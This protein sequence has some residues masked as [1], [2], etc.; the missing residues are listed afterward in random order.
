MCGVAGLW[1][2]A[3]AQPVTTVSRMLGTIRHRG[4]DSE[5]L[6]VSEDRRLALGHRRLAIV[7]LTA[8][9]AQPMTSRSGR[10]TLVFNGEIYN[11]LELRLCLKGPWRGHSDTETLLAAIERMGLEHALQ[12]CVGM[13][14]IALWDAHEHTLS[15]A[16]DRLG[17]KPLY[18][19]HAPGVTAFSSELKALA[20]V[21][22]I[23]RT[24][25]PESLRHYVRLGYIPAPR[26][27]WKGVSKLMPG[28]LLVLSAPGEGGQVRTYWQ[29][30]TPTGQ[31]SGSSGS[32]ART[33]AQWLDELESMLDTAVSGQMLSDVPLGAFLS[34]GIDSSLI[35]A[36]M[37]RASARPVRT[38][39]MGV[40]DWK[41]D[42]SVHAARVA[43]HLGTDHTTLM[44][45]PTDVLAVVPDLV[46]IYDEPFA[47]SSQ[48]PTVL[49]SRL[50]RSHV[51][52]ALSGDAGDELFGGYNRHVTADRLEHALN[53][54][55]VALRRAAGTALAAVPARLWDALASSTSLR[56]AIRL[57]PDMSEKMGRLARFLSATSSQQAYQGTVSQWLDDARMPV[58]GTLPALALPTCDSVPLA[59][60]MMW[61]DMQSYLPD[62][63]LVKVD[64]AAMSCSL[65][66]RVPLLDH[67]IVELALRMPMALKIRGGRS[68]WV[69]RELL[70]RRVPRE[71][72]E[73]PKQGFSLPLAQ[74]LR[75]PLRDW[76]ESLLTPGQLDRTGLW[77]TERVRATWD[78]HQR[79]KA[80]HQRALWTVLMLQAWL[81]VPQLPSRHLADTVPVPA[82]SP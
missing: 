69:L 61:W 19:G 36:P 20:P 38:F 74:W 26:S 17:E 25:D 70:A 3:E 56:G 65:E 1:S 34:G 29:L 8:E 7:D 15:L 63:I 14:A 46:R 80:N 24:L 52:V 37:Q 12:A 22:R 43:K 35:V 78:E 30:P 39:S 59:Q 53:A 58:L 55:P 28:T 44:V 50:T 66:T 42:E 2:S 11:H 40:R 62:D 31:T 5:G 81:G 41:D 16:R 9:G 6:W 47:D 51:T 48:V 21:E 27:A 49:L 23:D 45:A 60:Q 76:A 77:A 75:G 82:T 32:Y 10:Y 33:D 18:V 64:R 68:K 79:G 71:M 72:I 4:P 67:R 54:V 57:P 73:R 13:F